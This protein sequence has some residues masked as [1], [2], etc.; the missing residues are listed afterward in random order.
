MSSTKQHIS[1]VENKSVFSSIAPK[2]KYSPCFLTLLWK[3]CLCTADQTKLKFSEQ[4]MLCLNF[5]LLP[6]SCFV[7]NTTTITT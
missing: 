3:F 7:R 4:K 5:R 1:K 6:N 2:F